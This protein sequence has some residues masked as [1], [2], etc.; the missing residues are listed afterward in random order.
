M[1][2]AG[3]ASL[4]HRVSNSPQIYKGADLMA[5]K[6]GKMGQTNNTLMGSTMAAT[7]GNM[8]NTL[9]HTRS[10]PFRETISKG[11]ITGIG[12]LNKANDTMTSRK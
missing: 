4:M 2:T 3:K 10:S 9:E 1:M 5:T 6:A 12:L 11:M 7:T 8:M